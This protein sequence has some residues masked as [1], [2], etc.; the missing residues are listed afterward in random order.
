MV[1]GTLV[2]NHNYSCSFYIFLSVTQKIFMTHLGGNLSSVF[3]STSQT[4]INRA[5]F[6]LVLQFFFLVLVVYEPLS[7]RRVNF[8]C[9]DKLS[10]NKM[11][12]II[13]H[14]LCHKWV[15]LSSIKKFAERLN[16]QASSF[17]CIKHVY[18]C[19]EQLGRVSDRTETERKTRN[20]H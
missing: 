3:P 7:L 2:H 8:R 9:E 11:L 18:R 13:K 14:R 10:G 6:F 16:F 4:A 15:F 17:S 20:G 1:N 19:Q 5:S 12:Y